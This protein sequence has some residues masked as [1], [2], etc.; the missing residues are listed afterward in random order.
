MAETYDIAKAVEAQKEYCKEYAANHPEDWV[1][2][3]MAEGRGFAPVSGVCWCCHQNI[4]TKEGYVTIN[5]RRTERKT[6]GISVE[7]ARRELTTGCPFCYRSY[8]D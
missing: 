5:R 2:K 3:F 4:Y 1:S 8:V 7:R 6:E